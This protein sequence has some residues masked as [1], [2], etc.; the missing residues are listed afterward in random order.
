MFAPSQASEPGTQD[1]AYTQGLKKI[2]KGE[3]RAA[4]NLWIPVRTNMELQGDA[5]FRIGVK[6]TEA[7]TSAGYSELYP[8]ATEFYLWGLGTTDFERDG[9]YIK[10]EIDRLGPLLDDGV[11]QRWKRMADN[12]DVSVLHEIRGFFVRNNPILTTPKN[13]RLIEHWERIAHARKNY[14]R[15]QTSP[16]GTDDR[17][18]TY[19]KYGEPDRVESGFFTLNMNDILS[20]SSEVINQQEH[21]R[22]NDPTTESTMQSTGDWIADEVFKDNLA[23]LI[24]ENVLTQRVT[25]EYE[26]WIYEHRGLGQNRNTTFMFGVDAQTRRFGMHPSVEAFIPISAFRERTMRLGGYRFNVGPIIQ[27]AY[28]KD[29]KFVDDTYLD[30][31]YDF[32]DRLMSDVNIIDESSFSNLYHRYS[33]QLESIRRAIPVKT[34]VYDQGLDEFEVDTRQY[35]FFDEDMEPYEIIFVYSMPHP[36]ILSDYYSFTGQ[37][38][39]TEPEYHLRHTLGWYSNSWELLDRSNDFPLVFFDK[40]TADGRLM[41]AISSFSIPV[42]TEDSNLLF[43]STLYN[44]SYS[45]QRDIQLASSEAVSVSVPADILAEAREGL[46]LKSTADPLDDSATGFSDVILGYIPEGDNELLSADAPIPFLVPKNPEIPEGEDLDV[47]FDVYN[48]SALNAAGEEST[49]V[50]YMLRYSIQPERSRGFF[51]RVFGSGDELQQSVVLNF[52]TTENMFNHY[53]SIETANYPAGKYELH[54]TL[55]NK[56]EEAIAEK[57]LP[58]AIIADS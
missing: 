1:D 58:F 52:S 19:V 49:E 43:T 2:E 30:I 38:P 50:A 12:N 5:D 13:E 16:Y 42:S 47:Y 48:L 44:K 21:A 27:L 56:S 3:V 7:I 55:M 24:S 17:G 15:N 11:H 26:V 41:P 28:Y 54:I 51:G 25:T 23:K 46:T 34:S 45:G 35:R 53:L 10:Q 4:I 39:G 31:Y 20:I 14:T 40:F 18:I 8:L 6:A 57:K 37:N 9:K 22:W 36:K 32:Y 33:D 29:L